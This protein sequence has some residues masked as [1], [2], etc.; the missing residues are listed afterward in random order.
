MLSQ[1]FVKGEALASWGGNAIWLIQD[2]LLTY[3]EESTDF[4]RNRFDDSQGAGIFL[5]YTMHDAGIKYDLTY[6]ETVRG[7]LRPLRVEGAPAYMTDM[8]GAGYVPSL[9]TLEQMLL[10]RPRSSAATNW[11]DTRW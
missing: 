4:N 9:E 11:R 8:V 6:V 7:P 3:I 10:L 2:E 1:F 5:V